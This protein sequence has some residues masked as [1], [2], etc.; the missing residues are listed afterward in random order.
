MMNE[1]QRVFVVWCYGFGVVFSVAS[2][3]L[4]VYSD[5]L[6]TRAT[7]VQVLML[8]GFLMLLTCYAL[9]SRTPFRAQPDKLQL[10]SNW[11]AGPVSTTAFVLAAILA[12]S[13]SDD[14]PKALML[15]FF[16]LLLYAVFMFGWRRHVQ[17]KHHSTPPSG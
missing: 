10:F 7:A 13:N 9:E 17:R 2:L 1:R 6:I 3:A 5:G 16:A 4:S 8:L 11:I 14:I 12:L 15:S